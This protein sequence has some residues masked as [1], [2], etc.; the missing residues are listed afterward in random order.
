MTN[1]VSQSAT[2]TDTSALVAEFAGSSTNSYDILVG[3]GLV[4]DSEAVF[5]QYK[6]DDQK[7][8]LM[9]P[10]GKPVTR[11]YPVQITGIKIEEN[12]YASSGFDGCKLNIEFTTQGGK[13]VCLTS[14]LTTMW[15]Q[16]MLICLSGLMNQ[17]ALGHLIAIDTW[18]GNSKYGTCFAAIRD[19]GV[20]V[21]DQAMYDTL[22][23]ARATKNHDL[24]DQ[25]I[26]D[27]VS[28]LQGCL[29]IIPTQV[30]EE[31]AF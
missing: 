2:S 29:S 20:K 1:I 13:V 4:K 16:C 31:E 30:T 10:N 23:E 3:V 21:S 9:Q 11:I 7:E 15:S 6:G 28:V 17:R 18:K 26:R 24:K 22:K 5:F 8:A 19:N 27:T 25:V 12:P 14:G